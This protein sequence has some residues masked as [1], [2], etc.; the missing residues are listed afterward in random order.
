MAKCST[1]KGKL[2][3]M[4][5]ARAKQIHKAKQAAAARVVT[6]SAAKQA[7]GVSK[8]GSAEHHRKIGEGVRRYHARKG[9]GKGKLGS[10][11]VKSAKATHK[12]KWIKDAVKH[13]GALHK[14]LGIPQGEKIPAKTLNAAAKAPGKLGLRARLAKTLNGIRHHL[15]F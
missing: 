11:N 8:Y 14:E 4:N 10:I 5:V 3:G 1:K 9:K 6:K 12:A 15:P 13:K 7:S 2:G